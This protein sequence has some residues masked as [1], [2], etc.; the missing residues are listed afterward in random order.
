M[1]EVGIIAIQAT[2][3]AELLG[4]YTIP[5]GHTQDNPREE[6]DH[7]MEKQVSTINPVRLYK[8]YLSA[9]ESCGL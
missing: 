4:E 9:A 2:F 1:V 5:E 6:H 3:T 7:E 8:F